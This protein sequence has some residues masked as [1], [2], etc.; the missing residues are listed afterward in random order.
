MDD[1]TP[2]QISKYQKRKLKKLAKKKKDADAAAKLA[3]GYIRTESESSPPNYAE[4]EAGIRKFCADN[5]VS[6]VKIFSDVCDGRGNPSQRPGY[7]RM[8]E[9]LVSN[10]AGNVVVLRADRID[11][12]SVV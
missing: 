2:H 8:R 4:Q 12:K 10:A 11:R 5:D 7:S 1:P 3:V 9:A 6:L